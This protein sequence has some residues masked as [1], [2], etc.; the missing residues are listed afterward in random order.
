MEL[1]IERKPVPGDDN[2]GHA[3]LMVGVTVRNDSA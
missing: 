3:G 2:G 1:L